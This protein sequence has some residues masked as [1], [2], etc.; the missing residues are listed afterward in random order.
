MA[1]AHNQE[2]V[3]LTHA[4]KCDVDADRLNSYSIVTTAILRAGR[5]SL[6]EKRSVAINVDESGNYSLQ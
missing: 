2:H 3:S 5:I 4:G 6:D 1:I